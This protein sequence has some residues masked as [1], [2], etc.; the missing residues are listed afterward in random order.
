MNQLQCGVQTCAA[1][2]EGQCCRPEIHVDGMRARASAETC[3]TS[4]QE[5]IPGTTAA[6]MG[7]TPNPVCDVLC[8]A[9]PCVHWCNGCCTAAEVRIDGGSAA[10]EGDTACASFRKRKA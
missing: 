6:V 3:C 10:C 8:T 9:Q 7:H 2:L 4:F 5:E 1:W